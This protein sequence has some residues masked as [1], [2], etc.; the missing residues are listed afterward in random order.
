MH[1]K[2]LFNYKNSKY[3]IILDFSIIN[4]AFYFLDTLYSKEVECCN[5]KFHFNEIKGYGKVKKTLS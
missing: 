5:L 4:V 2:T 3:E 1:T